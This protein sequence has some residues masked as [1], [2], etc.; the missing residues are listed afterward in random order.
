MGGLGGA[1]EV[2]GGHREVVVLG[3]RRVCFSKVYTPF[4]KK[5]SKTSARLRREAA[6]MRSSWRWREGAM[7]ARTSALG[8]RV[9]WRFS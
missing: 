6:A 5:S 4:D 7:W 2:V 8:L 1:G 3:L 9:G